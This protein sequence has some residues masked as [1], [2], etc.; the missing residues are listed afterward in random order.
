MQ[1]L[2]RAIRK[3]K[4]DHFSVGGFFL[5]VVFL[6]E[7]A[8]SWQHLWYSSN[9]DRESWPAGE[10]SS[11]GST[12]Y[13]RFP[14]YILCTLLLLPFHL[15]P[16]PVY[17]TGYSFCLIP[18]FLAIFILLSS[19]QQQILELYTGCFRFNRGIP[20]RENYGIIFKKFF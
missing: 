15:L 4:W 14:S 16:F 12:N 18:G 7:L 9:P 17:P 10:P 20:E 8:L 1:A 6:L 13:R 2:G 5:G 3:E 11:Q 19:R